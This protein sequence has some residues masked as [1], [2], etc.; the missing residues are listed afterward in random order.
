MRELHGASA[1]AHVAADEARVFF[2]AQE[3]LFCSRQRPRHPRRRGCCCTKSSNISRYQLVCCAFPDSSL[4]A[5]LTFS[6][7]AVITGSFFIIY[8]KAIHSGSSR[9]S[10]KTSA[11]PEPLPHSEALYVLARSVWHHRASVFFPS[12]HPLCS[13]SSL[14]FYLDPHHCISPN[15]LRRR[16]GLRTLH[17]PHRRL[18]LRQ[19]TLEVPPVRSP[20]SSSFPVI[21]Y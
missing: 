7:R 8:N 19:V 5:E 18:S 9:R 3:C 16:R 17:S 13:R 14:F 4:D 15:P 1:A 10:S 21:L 2:W 11:E 12:L 6:A 20:L